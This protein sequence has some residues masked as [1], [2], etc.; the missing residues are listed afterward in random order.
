[1]VSS[2]EFTID[3]ELSDEQLE[4]VIGGAP[5]GV[6]DIWRS[7]IINKGFRGEDDN[8]KIPTEGVEV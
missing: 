2:K 7:N 1:M 4:L 8:N 3:E 5:K 6:F